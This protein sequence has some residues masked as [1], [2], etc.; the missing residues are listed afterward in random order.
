MHPYY[1]GNCI[2]LLPTTVLC[3]AYSVKRRPIDCSCKLK[4]IILCDLAFY[5]IGKNTINY[6]KS[7]CEGESKISETVFEIHKKITPWNSSSI[8]LHN[9]IQLC[10][11]NPV[12]SWLKKPRD[13]VKLSAQYII[14]SLI[15]NIYY[16]PSPPHPLVHVHNLSL[17]THNHMLYPLNT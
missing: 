2:V 16:S 8:G 13:S 12:N 15:K 9:N 6:F 14:L 10:K 11:S 5:L 1:R 7:H 3:F 4:E 17:M